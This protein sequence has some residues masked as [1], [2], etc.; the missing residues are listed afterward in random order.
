MKKKIILRI[1]ISIILVVTILLLLLPGI[2]KRYAINNSKELV[3]RQIDMSKLKVNY[4]KAAVKIIDFKMYE[5]NE[6]DE[7]ISF[8]TLI[9]NL[10]PFNLFKEELVIEQLYLKGLVTRIVQYDSSFNF[11]EL[12]AYHIVREDPIVE[13]SASKDPYKFSF[14]NIEFSDANI[15]YSD[16][17]IGKTLKMKDLDLFIPFIGWNQEYA[18]EA[19]LRFDFERE[20]FFQS[21]FHMHPIHG[22]FDAQIIINHLYLDPFYEYTIPY[23]NISSLDGILNTNL[24]IEGNLY[25]AEKSL[26]SGTIDLVNFEMK[27]DS[28]RKFLGAKKLECL[29]KNVDSYNMKYE[30]DSLRLT[31]PYVYFELEDSTNNFFENFNYSYYEYD[32]IDL[33][34]VPTHSLSAGETDDIYYA[35]NSVIIEE[36]I[37]DYR[38]VLTGEP[39]DYHL[40]GVSVDMDSLES[41]S[42][43]V[44]IYSEML[45]NERGKL[46]A[47]FG[48][49]PLDPM[50]LTLDFVVTDFQLADL[51]IY[52]NHY[53][54]HAIVQGD[55]YYRSQTSILKGIIESEN[56]LVIHDATVDKEAGGLQKLPLKFALFIL[57]DKDGVINLDVPVRGDLNDPDLNVG[58]LV[59]TTFKNLIIKVATAPVRFF[60][61]LVGGETKDLESIDFA[62][63]DTTLSNNHIKQ[64]NMLL[65][66]EEKKEG[67]HIEMVYYNDIEKEK[68]EI[69]KLETGKIFFN[70]TG[71]QPEQDK[72][73]F[74]KFVEKEA[75]SDTLSMEAAYLKIVTPLMVDSIANMYMNARIRS[76]NNYLKF[77]NDST[78]IQTILGDPEAPENVNR[79]P[80]FVMKYS[81]EEE[82]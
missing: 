65:D 60:S 49:N 18:S 5:A 74:E 1:L 35:L 14:S 22:E 46:K 8:D 82:D 73:R 67:L 71:K 48:Y 30:I 31:E 78:L 36:G 32:S 15:Y 16:S 29:L 7:F 17:T 37:I 6:K 40:S 41:T 9:V 23:M 19:G 81:L 76:A 70:K 2:V 39:F 66:L 58:K 50:D 44:Q 68:E 13:D 28:S 57:K 61:D 56:K 54:G 62:Y 75:G 26:I 3:G 27:D 25:E 34:E 11:D 24:Q 33:A 12:I 64:L 52:T 42:E 80:G 72:K 55:M 77:A 63:N 51:N 10:E 59:W 4:F 21:S 45:L 43:W 53:L 69:T 38:D 20:G 47:E 79:K